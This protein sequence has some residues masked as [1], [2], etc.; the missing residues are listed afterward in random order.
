MAQLGSTRGSVK[1]YNPTK[2]FGFLTSDD[3]VDVFVHRSRLR[4]SESMFIEGARVSFT[5]VDTHKG[6][7]AV[8]VEIVR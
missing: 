8:D 3:G 4:D 7:A 2:G 1:W 6:K 5:I